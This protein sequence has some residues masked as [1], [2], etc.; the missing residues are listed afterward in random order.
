MFSGRLPDHL[1]QAGT[2]LAEA[3]AFD[4]TVENKEPLKTILVRV[5]RDKLN[6][7][8][9]LHTMRTGARAC[10]AHHNPSDSLIQ[11]GVI[12]KGRAAVAMNT[13]CETCLAWKDAEEVTIAAIKVPP[14]P[15]THPPTHPQ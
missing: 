15:T 1:L 12:L 5:H 14:P 4:A 7:T 11:F 8:R 9:A 3:S 2:V 6:W 10:S 13:L